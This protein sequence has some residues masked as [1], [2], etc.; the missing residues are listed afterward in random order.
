ML[1]L[2][3]RS[4]GVRHQVLAA[5]I[6]ETTPLSVNRYFSKENAYK[7]SFSKQVWRWRWR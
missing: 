5:P 3:T 4:A 6:Y 2:I 1:E 7:Y